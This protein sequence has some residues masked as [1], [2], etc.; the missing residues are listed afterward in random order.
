MTEQ[1][2]ARHR[3]ILT[4]LAVL[5][6]L[7]GILGL[8]DRPNVPFSGLHFQDGNLISFISEDSPAEH[9]GIL[10]GDRVLSVNGE[11]VFGRRDIDRM[12]RP[13][14]GE[15]QTL[16]I[17]RDG[18]RISLDLTQAGLPLLPA[19]FSIIGFSFLTAGLWA[20]LEAPSPRTLL[21]CLT[22]IGLGLTISPGPYFSSYALRMASESL[23]TSLP[24]LG[25]ACF[26]LFL[27]AFPRRKALVEKKIVFFLLLGPPIVLSIADLAFA[28]IGSATMAGLESLVRLA[29]GLL[30]MLYLILGLIAA[31][32]SYVKASKAE[33][34]AWGLNIML[35][36]LALGILPILLVDLV[37][38][39]LGIEFGGAEYS[40]I[41][42]ALVPISLA[43]AA[44]K[45]EKLQPGDT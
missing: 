2:A 1:R 19:L 7:W 42:L 35:A 38:L 11:P 10:V 16:E 20:Y 43:L 17:E 32:H 24:L 18:E 33:R 27:L 23:N 14:V 30:I 25:F 8:A 45:K 21:L 26:L 5:V 31:A 6:A 22:G 37:V 15:T 36:G 40:F 34:S 3:G 28:L 39:A 29:T 13:R 4:T 9:A 44:V 12:P 41:M